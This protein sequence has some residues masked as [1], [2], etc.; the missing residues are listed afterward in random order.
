MEEK[1]IK[2]S[3]PCYHHLEDKDL[4]RL[5]FSVVPSSLHSPMCGSSVDKYLKRISYP[6]GIS[7]SELIEQGTR[8]LYAEKHDGIYSFLIAR[9]G[10]LRVGFRSG[11]WFEMDISQHPIDYEAEAEFMGDRFIVLDARIAT[12]PI[13]DVPFVRRQMMRE[14]FVSRLRKEGVSA[15]SQKYYSV[16]MLSEIKKSCHE[17]IMAVPLDSM[18]TLV[19][20]PKVLKWKRVETIDVLLVSHEEV[21][22]ITEGEVECVD[23]DQCKQVDFS[24]YVLCKGESEMWDGRYVPVSLRTQFY[25]VGIWECYLDNGVLVP[26]RERK[27][28]QNPN[29][30]SVVKAICSRAGIRIA[31]S[32]ACLKGGGAHRYSFVSDIRARCLDCLELYDFPNG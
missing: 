4:L 12:A 27:D 6:I 3:Y 30:Y 25:Q 5:G 11:K 29:S 15:E 24:P 31:R 28:K 19:P 17:G 16:A 20:G 9:N 7:E 21:K 18:F 2:D 10:K 22:E 32:G 8:C 26:I 1:K 14:R 23:H 13:V